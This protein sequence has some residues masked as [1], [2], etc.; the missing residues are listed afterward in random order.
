MGQSLAQIYIHAVFSTK[1]RE[2]F[3]TEK[4]EIELHSYI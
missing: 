1:N 4:I 3:T 2:D